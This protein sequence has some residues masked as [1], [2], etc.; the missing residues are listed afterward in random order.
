[1]AALTWDF[2]D[3]TESLLRALDGEPQQALRLLIFLRENGRSLMTTIKEAGEPMER[4]ISL[5]EEELEADMPEDS[6]EPTPDLG[7]DLDADRETQ[8]ANRVQLE[9]KV[10]ESLTGVGVGR[11]IAGQLA[12][13]T[14][15]LY[16]EA[17]QFHREL[18][19]LK[20]SQ[21]GEVPWCRR[22]SSIC[23]SCSTSRCGT[24]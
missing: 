17:V 14:A 7:A 12:T 2:L 8:S 22:R 3:Y 15:D 20:G 23:S 5:L 13:R 18:N 21:P 19:R 11:E 4:L 9:S 1:M 16:A 10:R 6:A 24:S